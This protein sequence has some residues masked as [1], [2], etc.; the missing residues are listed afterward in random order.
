MKDIRMIRLALENF[1][2]H[3]S[4]VLDFDGQDRTVYGDNGSGKTSVYDGLTWLLFG[5]DSVGNGEK[6]VD[7]KPLGTDGN[8]ADHDAVTAVEA[9]LTVDGRTVQLR[10]TLREVWATRRGFQ[11]PVYDG[12]VSEYAVDGVPMKKNGFDAAVKELVDEGLFRMLTNVRY[13]SADMK[14]QDRRAVLFDMAGNLTDGQIME[15]D[16]RFWG[17]KEA[18]GDKP[19]G[20][21]KARLLAERKRLNGARNDGPARMSECQKLIDSLA[22]QDFAGARAEALELD[23]QARQLREELAALAAGGR[24]R[25]IGYALREKDAELRALEARNRAYREQQSGQNTR[26]EARRQKDHFIRERDYLKKRMENSRLALDRTQRE[27]EAYR[28]EWVKVNGEA[29]SGGM[30]PT[31]GQSLPFDQLKAKTEGFEADKKRRLKEIEQ[32]AAN[33]S[34]AA[35]SYRKD[36]GNAQTE[37]AEAERKIA[38]AEAKIAQDTAAV[39]LDLPE[40]AGQKAALE[41]DMIALEKER[42]ELENGEQE[43]RSALEER[44]SDVNRRLKDA[45]TRAAAEGSLRYATARLETLRRESQEAAEA[46]ELVERQI[47]IIEEFVRYKASFLESTVNAPFRLARFRLFREQANG[48][49]EERCDVTVDGVPYGSLNNAMQINVGID[50]INAL[51][52]YYGVRVPLFVDNAESITRLEGCGGQLIRL[53]VREEDKE[54]RMV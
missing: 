40:Y 16:E 45:Q 31:C 32:R 10:R 9:V 42:R 7:I 38:E 49:T 52:G 33:A 51:S 30:C 22:G 14:W 37:L 50:I 48:G 25:E 44:L 39:V 28:G 53:V 36:L 11:T 17:L 20:D 15:S 27:V 54:L 46:L 24:G 43:R 12:N 8:V 18:V 35:D 2:C 21:L 4:L 6:I 41:A 3:R 29:F 34:A 13:F 23:G 47:Y 19:L 26:E 5:K 1:K